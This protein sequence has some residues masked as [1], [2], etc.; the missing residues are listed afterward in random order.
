M[1]SIFCNTL[2][3]YS[4]KNGFTWFDSF[5]TQA[6]ELTDEIKG[7]FDEIGK[8]TPD[9]ITNYNKDGWEPFIKNTNVADETLKK[10]LNDAGQT[11][12]SLEAFKMY[13]DVVNKTGKAFN[14]AA[15]GAKAFNIALNM[16]IM[17][18]I[19][20]GIELVTGAIDN[21]IRRNEIAIETAA[22]ANENIKSI[23]N[24]FKDHKKLIDDYASTYDSLSKGIDKSTNKNVDLNTEDYEKYLD[25]NKQ[26]SEA[27]PS[28]ITGFDEQGNAIL[29]IGTNGATSAV[30]LEKLL[31]SEKEL[32]NYKIAQNIDD[33]F[34]GVSVNISEATKEAD[35]FNQSL[36]EVNNSIKNIADLNASIQ[37]FNKDDSFFKIDA[38]KDGAKEYTK[39]VQD[40]LKEIG[41]YTPET[42]IQYGPQDSIT[43]ADTEY[44]FN[45]YS[46]SDEQISQ[47]KD[48]MKEQTNDL[49]MSFADSVGTS[50]N[51]IKEQQQKLELAWKDFIPS[52]MATSQNS[53]SYKELGEQVQSAV[54]SMISNL[55]VDQSQ[56]IKKDYSGNVQSYIREQIIKPIYYAEPEV[57]SAYAKL[58]T[59]DPSTFRNFDSY[60][61]QV[62]SLVENIVGKDKDKQL[63]FK[64]KFNLDN[65]DSQK[66]AI[67]NKMNEKPFKMNVELSKQEVI[68]NI[69]SLSEGF[70]SL[71]K[72]MKSISD[73]NNPFDYALLDDGKFT[74]IFSA[75]NDGGEAYAN[76]IEKVSSSPKDIKATQSAFN[77]LVTT[78][79]DSTGV[80]N[81]LTDENA[82]LATAMLQNMGVAN[83]EEVVMS[84][85]AIAQEHLAAQK[86][87]TAEVSN[88]LANATASEIPGIIDEATQSDI[89]KV[90]LAG[91]VLEKEFFNGNALDTSGD[92]ENIISL[93][94]VI[95]SANTALQ[96]LNTLKAGG[97]VG[98]RIGKEGYDSIVKNA[99]QEVDD[100]IKAASEYKGKGSNVNASYTGGPKTNKPSGSKKDKKDTEKEIDWIER[101][102]QKAFDERE[103]LMK[104][105]SDSSIDYLGI[106]N[107]EFS[108]ATELFNSN[109]DPMSNG[110]NELAGIAKRAGMSLSELYT[111]IANG[112]PGESR[113][114]YLA[115]VLESDKTLLP[116]IENAV[117]QYKQKWEEAASKISAENKAKIEF[118][119]KDVETFSGDELKNVETAMGAF[120]KYKSMQDSY[121][122][123]Q[124]KNTSAMIDQYDNRIA[125]INKENEQLEK[126]NSLIESQ[127][128]YLK[129]M[130]EIPSAS[131]Y[132][133]LIR[134][135]GTEISNTKKEISA[136]K[137][138]LSEAFSKYGKNS[139]E[140]ADLEGEIREAEKSLYGMKK[141]QEEYNNKLLQ[142]PIENASILVSMYQDIGAAIQGWGDDVVASGGK[143]DANYY[144]SL[145]S[146]GATVVGQL[147]KQSSLIK[148]VMDN[149]DVGSDN[150]NE[151]YKQLQS[152]NSEMSSAIQNIR[153]FN[154]ELLKMPLEN[155][156]NY[157]SELDKVINGLREVQSEY[158]TVVSAVSGVIKNR[159]SELE[160]QRDLTNETAQ[161]EIDALN[162]KLKLLDKENEYNKLIFDLERKQFELE[163]A[164]SQN[165]N[166][167]NKIAHYYSNVIYE[168]SYNG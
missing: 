6:Y 1:I 5:K 19:A 14:F 60:E 69:N 89:A 48:R 131:L 122:E 47:L 27:F 101:D 90:A 163:R 29:S 115:Q 32:A 104:K 10:F 81:G 30:E 36:E 160:K 135:T 18:L 34:K 130:G 7:V 22:K 24:S 26:F 129:S 152:V 134:N 143:L 13:P 38:T 31:A 111:I 137:A 97:N 113:E 42:E 156:G 136:M 41:A 17:L 79:I 149:Y 102:I 154:E 155:I 78:W 105:A 64:A 123:A 71:D 33:A 77:N 72:I 80:L 110:A 12:K 125:A 121:S 140:Y 161:I 2:A 61:K 95:G 153:K 124:K 73:K 157:S 11:D 58:F 158:D 67:Q 3:N 82:N 119:Y 23:S 75:L 4:S 116:K 84:R 16:G 37:S 141:A 168:N 109:L 68:S 94:G 44:F 43:G 151:L 54:D 59:L 45:L 52:L 148:D 147:Q 99:Q 93:V 91:L 139:E 21:Y 57:K 51:G 8:L 106:T 74:K 15:L 100:A 144:Q 159:I 65:L 164:K 117:E 85:L 66:E 145:I 132:E 120:D 146:N 126:S 70:E 96:A 35:N 98:Y 40:A 62:N 86:A 166:R 127:I 55:N 9:N 28:L 107:E 167:V 49:N 46:L 165:T 87:Y 88:E 133:K 56:L 108:R 103:K 114:N 20:K 92:I 112:N 162:E 76:F 25:I 53:A 63:E 83:A 150:W 128:D 142:M 39:A 50:E 138:K 118:G